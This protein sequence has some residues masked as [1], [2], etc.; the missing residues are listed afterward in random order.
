MLQTVLLSVAAGHYKLAEIRDN[1]SFMIFSRLNCK[2]LLKDMQVGV[3]IIVNYQIHLR[4]TTVF[5]SVVVI[6]TN[7]TSKTAN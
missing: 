6:R 4:F 1:I 5:E 7:Y 3:D 2:F